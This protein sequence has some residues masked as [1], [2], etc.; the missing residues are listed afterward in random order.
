MYF[1]VSGG[2]GSVGRKGEGDMQDKSVSIEL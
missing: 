2:E 1:L